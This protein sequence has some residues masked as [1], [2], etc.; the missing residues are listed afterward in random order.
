M[1]I[2]YIFLATLIG[3]I[4]GMGGGVIIKP[5]LELIQISTF[6]NILFF[7]SVA[8]FSMTL[9]SINFKYI[10]IATSAFLGGL[11]GQVVYAVSKNY[12][13]IQ[14][15]QICM[16]VLLLVLSLYLTYT[17]ID[18]KKRNIKVLSFLLGSVSNF[19]GIG[20]GPINVSVYMKLS[21]KDILSALSLS[22][23]TIF[24]SQLPKMFQ[25]IIHY[26]TYEYQKAPYIVIEGILGGIVGKKLKTKIPGKYIQ[27]I[28]ILTTSSVLLVNLFNLK[29]ILW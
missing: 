7:S 9:I 21:K 25:I 28:Y 1:Y 14:A 27:I 20:G 24:F 13:Y 10:K 2:V 3:S 4:S 29:R 23:T 15:I 12:E 5:I 19:L 6:D 16:V 8:V 17:K 18:F 22:L 11:L 26:N